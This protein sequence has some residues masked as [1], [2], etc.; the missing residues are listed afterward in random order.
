MEKGLRILMLED[1]EEDTLLIERV[2][3]KGGM[4]FTTKR[5]DTRD[6]FSDAIAAFQ[7]DVVLSD[8]SMPQFNSLEALKIFKERTMMVPFILVT[9]AVSEE[10]AVNCLQEGADDYI[11]KSNLTRLPVAIMNAINKKKAEL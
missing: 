2:L 9:G 6:E 8:H 7:P 10:F 5:V 1:V 4:N 3:R 11:L